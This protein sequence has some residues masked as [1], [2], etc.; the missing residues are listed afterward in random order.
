VDDVGEF[1]PAFL[2]YCECQIQIENGIF[3][4]E[5]FVYEKMHEG[6]IEN[7]ISEGKRYVS[8]D[9]PTGWAC[10]VLDAWLKEDDNNSVFGEDGNPAWLDSEKIKE[11]LCELDYLDESFIDENEEG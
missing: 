10:E 5:D 9:A 3:L 8:A 6:T 7:I 11:L 4:D 2:K 1:T